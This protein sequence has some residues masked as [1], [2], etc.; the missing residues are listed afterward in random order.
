MGDLTGAGV[1]VLVVGS[2][3][4]RGGSPLLDVPAA[5]RSAR[6][7]ADAL[8]GYCGVAEPNVEVLIDPAILRP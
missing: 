3:T 8:V 1:R 7:V 5:A 2:A 4:Y 6:A